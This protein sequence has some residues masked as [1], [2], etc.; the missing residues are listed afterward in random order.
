M[1]YDAEYTEI[2]SQLRESFQDNKS[3][4]ETI[5]GRKAMI[6]NQNQRKWTDLLKKQ[7]ES[8][9]TTQDIYELRIRCNGE[10]E[11]LEALSKE[12]REWLSQIREGEKRVFKLMLWSVE[13]TLDTKRFIHNLNE[14]IE[15]TPELRINYM[16][17]GLSQPVKVTYVNREN[18]VK[19]ADFRSL[20]EKQQVMLIGNVMAAEARR[21]YNPQ[22]DIPIKMQIFIVK[23]KQMLVLLSVYPYLSIPIGIRGM[24]FKVFEGLKVKSSDISTLSNEKVEEM[25]LKLKKSCLDYWKTELLPVGEPLAVPGTTKRFTLKWDSCSV[26][27]TI[28][29]NLEEKLKEFCQIHKTNRNVLILMAWGELLGRYYGKQEVILAVKGVGEHLNVFPIKIRRTL[30]RLERIADI[31]RQIRNFARYSACELQELCEALGVEKDYF[32]IV[33]HFIELCET[34]GIAGITDTAKEYIGNFADDTNAAL[35]MNYHAFGEETG[36]NY[37]YFSDCIYDI[38][39]EKLHRTFLQLLDEQLSVEKKEFNLREYIELTDSEEERIQKVQT[40]R[41]ALYLRQTG[42]FMDRTIEELMQL[43]EKTRLQSYS[44]SD[45]VIENHQAVCEAAFLVEGNVEES[46]TDMDGIIKTISIRKAGEIFGIE[47]LLDNNISAFS[48]TVAGK[49]AKILWL[50]RKD[51]LAFLSEK[52]ENWRVLLERVH[53]ETGKMKKLWTMV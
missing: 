53:E 18:C 11:K 29:K 5:L 45:V 14:I 4:S 12:E 32:Q 46:R 13:G 24:V 43:A 1:K 21:K 30:S 26:Y 39:L 40:A 48:Y 2:L 8:S 41:K 9:L 33:H 44:L 19:I 42:L 15:Q 10:I 49:E 36:I 22:I 34:E 20:E 6:L 23:G 38:T 51:F 16:Y 3:P 37:A 7:A 31:T 35:T 25:N 47:A 28:D 27:K 17:Q 50:E 52:P